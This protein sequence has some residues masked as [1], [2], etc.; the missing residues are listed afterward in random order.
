[1]DD[2]GTPECQQSCVQLMEAVTSGP[3][4]SASGYN[5]FRLAHLGEVWCLADDCGS[6]PVLDFDN[7]DFVKETLILLGFQLSSGLLRILKEGGASRQTPRSTPFYVFALL[8]SKLFE[9]SF[10]CLQLFS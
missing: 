1:M 4:S 3:I 7:L 5:L 8:S 10:Y 6:E 2:R 9:I